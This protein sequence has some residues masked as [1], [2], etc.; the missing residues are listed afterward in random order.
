MHSNSNHFQVF[1]AS[2]QDNLMFYFAQKLLM[3]Y[4]EEHK[5]IGVDLTNTHHP[6]AER[7][8]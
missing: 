4:L 6:A 1:I 7:P 8:S 5:Q 3:L 2:W